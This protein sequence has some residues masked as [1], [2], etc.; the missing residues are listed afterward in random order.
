MLINT[1]VCHCALESILKYQEWYSSILVSEEVVVIWTLKMFL[2]YDQY[3]SR[4]TNTRVLN[5][6][7]K[8]SLSSKPQYLSIHSNTRVFKTLKNI[9]PFCKPNT[10]VIISLLEYSRVLK[11]LIKSFSSQY[12]SIQTNTWV[13]ACFE[14]F[15]EI[16]LKSILEFSKQYLSIHKHR[17]V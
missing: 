15:E 3:S 11:T 4:Q 7:M 10:R 5:F 13:F 17:K 1:R 16:L 6:D 9:N 8:V 14:N 2:I 12:W